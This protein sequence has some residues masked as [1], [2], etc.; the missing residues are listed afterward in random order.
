MKITSTAVDI[1][2]KRVKDIHIKFLILQRRI[3]RLKT[4]MS[5]KGKEDGQ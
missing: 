4:G 2:P 3:I 5:G 1:F